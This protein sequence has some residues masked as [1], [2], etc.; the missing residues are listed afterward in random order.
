MYIRTVCPTCGEVV[1]H[2]LRIHERET[3]RASN[4]FIEIMDIGTLDSCTA[5]DLA[6]DALKVLSNHIYDGIFTSELCRILKE[7]FGIL[8]RHCCDIV[9]QLKIELNMYCPDRQH[10]YYV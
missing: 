10:S 9:Q 6:H 2:N 7:K 4:S 3:I 5:E 1:Y 8:A